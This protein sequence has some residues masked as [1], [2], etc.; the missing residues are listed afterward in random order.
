MFAT[1]LAWACLS[2]GQASAQA[3]MGPGVQGPGGIALVDM[4]LILR[5]HSRLKSEMNG[6][7]ARADASG[8]EFEKA[9]QAIQDKARALNADVKPGSPEFSQKEEALLNEQSALKTRAALVRK[10]F[11]QQESKLLYG[12]YKEVSEDVAAY[13]RSAALCWY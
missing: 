6:L 8:A 12:A 10:E 13:C 7:K 9:A 1:C 3:P 11:E 2:G 4:T 5:N